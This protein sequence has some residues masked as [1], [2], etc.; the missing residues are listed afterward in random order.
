MPRHRERLPA[1]QRQAKALIQFKKQHVAHIGVAGA[2]RGIGGFATMVV[3]GVRVVISKLFEATDAV[4][5]TP[6]GPSVG[7]LF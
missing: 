2:G 5:D 1:S 4:A 7:V 3:A 6:A